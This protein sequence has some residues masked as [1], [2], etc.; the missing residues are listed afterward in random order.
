MRF[1]PSSIQ[2]PSERVTLR[3]L[4]PGNLC[5]LLSH[6]L[7]FGLVEAGTSPGRVGGV[8]GAA[9]DGLVSVSI[10]QD[11]SGGR[12]AITEVQVFDVVQVNPGDLPPGHRGLVFELVFVSS[13][14]GRAPVAVDAD[15]A[16]AATVKF[17][18]PV[19]ATGERFTARL[20][21]SG[22]WRCG[23]GLLPMTARVGAFDLDVRWGLAN[24]FGILV[25]HKSAT[26]PLQ[27]NWFAGHVNAVLP[28]AGGAN[29]GAL[30]VGTNSGGVWL[31]RTATPDTP[32]SAEP[33]SDDWDDPDSSCLVQGLDDAEHF[34][35]G[36]SGQVY[37]TNPRHDASI[38]SWRRITTRDYGGIFAIGIVP[39]PPPRIVLATGMGVFWAEIPPLGSDYLWRAVTTMVDGSTF[40]PGTYSGLAV[41][42]SRV[43]V[44]AWG[45]DIGSHHY[46]VFHGDWS[47][48]DLR[49]ARSDMPPRGPIDF[50]SV[51]QNMYRTSLAVCVDDPTVL[52]AVSSYQPNP[53]TRDHETLGALLRS[54][55]GGRSWALLSPTV[56]G[57]PLSVLAGE[58]GYYNNCIAVAPTQG[59]FV[60]IG[61]QRG[62]FVSHDGGNTFIQFNSD[63][64][65][66]LHDDVHGLT[67]DPADASG[68]TLYIA[69]DGGVAVTRDDGASFDST[70]NRQLANLE[71]YSTYVT[72]DFY[73][74]LSV[75]GD[76]IA[77]GLQ[78]N[79]NVVSQL[80]APATQTPWAPV[81]RCDGGVVTFIGTGQVLTDVVCGGTGSNLWARSL[82]GRSL[83][84]I[85]KGAEVSVRAKN[86]PDVLRSPILEAV[87]APAFRNGDGQL[88]YAVASPFNTLQVFGLFAKSDGGDLH[89]ELIGT[90]PGGN[91]PDSVNALASLDGTTVLIGTSSGRA[92]QLTP[93]SRG[94]TSATAVKV[95]DD[96]PPG[97]MTRILVISSTLAFANYNNGKTGRIIRFDG[98][99]W[100]RSDAGLPGNAC[101]GLASQGTTVIFTCTDDRVFSSRNQGQ[102]WM[103]ASSGLPRRPHCADLRVGTTPGGDVIYVS[104]FGRSLW[105][106]GL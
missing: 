70:G 100:I 98:Q 102:T 81:D 13:S 76:L 82:H 34:Y 57:N 87:V 60:A 89:A 23:G 42:G 39:G 45:V 29:A 7:D 2:G 91:Q 52:Y 73:G 51:D 67:F 16:V 97:V 20:T 94:P 58:Q 83:Y 33:L 77:G 31:V 64:D 40:P 43:V 3:P 17:N 93:S 10:E 59:N 101:Y 27:G 65:P 71:F 53:A 48:G 37:E 80:T 25:N 38:R 63:R 21:F 75:Q 62:A 19:E 72:R 32:A 104:T 106:A 86:G 12:F 79:G 92:L 22:D 46:G 55:D 28:I 90:V 85:D 41:S 8:I 49:M 66:N 4:A 95:A 11:T 61:W 26:D 6:S 96:V 15:Q 36:S 68:R 47:S 30:L 18:A 5:Q 35:A 84:D 14:D 78:D 105:V 24:P 50:T 54:G 56:N 99:T 9:A 1:S 74:T 69:S 44:A 88:M 103:N